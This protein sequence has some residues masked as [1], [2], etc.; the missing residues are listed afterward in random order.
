MGT[1]A[2]FLSLPR[3]LRN[4]IYHHYVFEPDGYHFDY[5]SGKLR[6]SGNRLID[7]ALMYT[8]SLVATEMHHLALRSNAIHFYTLDTEPKDAMY[9][10]RYLD[11]IEH[12]K[13]VILAAL[14][15]PEFQ[16]Y[17][18]SNVDDEVALRYPQ[19]KSL[20]SL[21]ED[22]AWY[23]WPPFAHCDQGLGGSSWGEADSVFRAFQDYMIHLVLRDTDF[24]EALANFFDEPHIEPPDL[25]AWLYRFKAVTDGREFA[26][27]LRRVLRRRS[28][29]PW[30]IP[31]KE[32]FTAH[33]DTG[34]SPPLYE[35][36]FWERVRWRL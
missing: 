36:N 27:F 10:D 19:F 16:H 28:L 35:D 17:R 6:A 15:V 29:D 9:F 13:M 20:L 33:V 4:T 7:L 12:S 14:R 3:E 26:H 25:R 22:E 8:C 2:S 11:L 18:T 24:P 5:D 32:E 31:S 1:P 34:L 21:P 30:S 23:R